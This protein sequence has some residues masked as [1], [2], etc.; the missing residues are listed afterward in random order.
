MSLGWDIHKEFM[1]FRDLTKLEDGMGEKVA[2]FIHSMVAFVGSIVLALVK[3][4]QLALV[5]MMATL[6]VSFIVHGI[7]AAVI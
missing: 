5:C 2:M 7:V 6:P 3:G 1:H 4:W